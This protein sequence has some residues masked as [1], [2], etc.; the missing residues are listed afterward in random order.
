M[1]NVPEQSFPIYATDEDV[2]VRAGGDFITL[3]PAWQQMA[4]GN[5]GFFAADSPW[6]F[7]SVSTSFQNNNVYPNQ[8]LWLT[9]PKSVYP[10]GGQLLAV[11][12]VSGSSLTLRRLHQNLNIGQPA[13]PAAGLTGIT[14]A[15]NTLFPQIEEASFAIKRQYGIDE[16]ITYRDSSWVYD[17]R[18]LRIATVLWVLY[19]RYTAETRT[20][21][22]DFA[23]KASVI[24]N[25][26]SQVL[27]RVQ[28]R[29]GP[30]GNSAEPSTVFSCKLT[31]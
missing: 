30:Y 28:V 9:G 25:Q 5:D 3:C 20:E 14:F 19:D 26:L 4:A 18:D 24:K 15:I 17:L 27:D 21:R 8:V 22:G 29:W 11:D 6:I 7:N 16:N 1:S 31:R 23:R 12:S 2:A 13:G 10:G